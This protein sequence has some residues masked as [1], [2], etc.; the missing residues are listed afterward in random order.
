MSE[1]SRRLFLIGTAGAALAAAACSAP[2]TG[3]GGR[4]ASLSL[5][6]ALLPETLN[7][8]AGADSNGMGKINEGLLTLKAKPNDLPDLVPQL[9]ASPPEPSEDAKTWTVKI[10]SGVTFSDGTPLTADDVVATYKA[11]I[12]PAT[13]SPIAGDLSMLAGIEAPD[14]ATVVF[15]LNIPYVAFPTKLLVG[16]APASAIVAGQKVEESALNQKPI[17]TGPYVVESFSNGKLVYAANARF[18]DGAPAVKK[19]TYVLAADDNTRAQQ[20]TAGEYDGSVLPPRL[21]ANFKKSDAVDVIAATSADWR[22][23]SLP[24]DNPVT[25]DP[26]VR[27]ALNLAVDRQAMLDSVLMGYGRIA[28]TF[29]P[30]QYVDYYSED[31]VFPYELDK[32]KSMLDEAGWIEG[33]D[34]IRHKNGVRAAFTVMYKPEDRLRKDLSAAFASEALKAGFDVSIEGQGFDVLEPRIHKDAVMLGGGDTPYDVDSQL[35]SMLHS[36]Y[37]AAG[38]YY[39]NPSQYANPDMDAALDLGR[40]SLTTEDRVAAYEKVQDIY[41]AEPS[42]VVLVFVD[43]TYVQLK[44][45]TEAWNGTQTILEPHEHGTAW[46]PWVNI[47]KWTPKK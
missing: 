42:M 17:G 12:D 19:V 9:A 18:R 23:I 15:T 10:R 11:I 6:T 46:G 1:F 25:S 21:A 28:S 35:Y 29:I 39:D 16:I 45:V 26:A 32:A 2:T 14:P 43:H 41:L 5:V 8:I 3:G 38:A 40:T 47:E 36:S 31:A 30:P 13:A 4:S 24:L 27:M 34:G 44:S 37:P 20:M 22:G 33:S 7:P